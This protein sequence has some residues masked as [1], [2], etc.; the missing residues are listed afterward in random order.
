MLNESSS[1]SILSKQKISILL[2]ALKDR[3]ENNKNREE[4]NLSHEK[5]E[6]ENGPFGSSTQKQHRLN[7][8]IIES[9]INILKPHYELGTRNDFIMYLSGWM[10]KVWISY[11]SAYKVIQHIASSDEEKEARLGTLDETYKKQDVDKICGY[12]GLL[13]LLRDQLENEEQAGRTLKEIEDL[14]LTNTTG[15]KC[16]KGNKLS[17]DPAESKSQVQVIIEL[18]KINA[19]LFFKD[20]N[21]IPNIKIK[22]ADY[23]EVMPVQSRRFEY[24]VSKLYYDRTAGKRVASSESLTNA[25]HQIC[26][27]SLFSGK[28]TRLSL[29]V[30]WGN[31]N[32]EIHYDLGDVV[33]RCIKITAFGWEIIKHS[34]DVLFIRFN[35]KAQVEPDRSYPSDIFDRFLDMMHI[36]DPGRRLLA[37]VWIVCLF[38]PEFPH[39]INITYGE[40]GGSKS[41]F[42]R[43]V[44]RLVDPDK[45]ELLTIPKDKTEFVQQLYHNYLAIYD[46]VKHLSPWFS[47]EACKAVT[48]I[49]NSKRSLYTNDEDTIYNYK[50]CIMING[51]NNNLTEP[52]ALDRSILTEFVR[53]PPEQRKEEAKI[54]VVFEEMRAKLLGHILDVLVRTLEIKPTIELYDLPRMADFAVWGEA[55]ARAMRY[56]PTEFVNAYNENIGRQNVEA[57]E[58]NPLA[59]A[60]D[61]FVDSWYKEGKV[62]FWQG[63][64]KEGL[65]Q[66]NK[67]AQVYKI[68]TFDRVWPKAPNSLTRRLRPILSNLR[69]G[70]G[71]NVVISRQTANVDGVSSG[72]GNI[73]KKNTST[74]RIE[75]ISPPSPL[76]PPKENRAQNQA[77]NGG[78]TLDNGDNTS[79]LQQISPPENDQNRAQKTESGDSG[80][81]NPNLSDSQAGVAIEPV[82]AT[83]P[84]HNT[85]ATL[86]NDKNSIFANY[87][88]FDL[89]WMIYD[90]DEKSIYAASFVNN[91]GSSKVLHIT[92]FNSEQDLLSAIKQELML[93]PMSMGWNTTGLDSDLTILN[94][95]CVKNGIQSHIRYS[96]SGI[97]IY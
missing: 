24:Y 32:Q 4:S 70:L 92:D 47:D 37:K 64:T 31:Q 9:I 77:K 45:I 14:F 67:I 49:G 33:W 73:S 72:Y 20:Q 52:D 29:R 78:D 19:V 28:E 30:A 91:M 40:K 59:Q 5:I 75:K 68:D 83:S 84:S 27:Y 60:V 65:E 53:I 18:V 85:S 76:P 87:V 2:S 38:I 12:S 55:I 57:I 39:P 48:G 25:I 6:I 21:G 94:E 97:T 43:F 10:R 90:S 63:S 54:E 74:L 69:E 8:E 44:K 95:R 88:A 26:A 46:N 86:S 7:D 35:Q 11:E 23:A 1:L 93:Y 36:K 22:V 3:V 66:L 41:T 81:I 15:S 71:I 61:R 51:I 96:D 58:S 17:I 34:D 16:S 50:R 13:S 42:C 62:T 82:I 80:D 89:E 79:T 56:E